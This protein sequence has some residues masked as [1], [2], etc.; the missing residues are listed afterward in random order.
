[1]TG[2]TDGIGKEIAA[3]LATAG[4]RVLIVGRDPEKGR[5]AEGPAV[6]FLRADL[7][8]GREADRLASDVADRVPALSF[9]VHSAGIVRGRRH[10]SGEGIESNFAV[11]Y[12]SRFV[13]STRLQPL[14]D[15]AAEVEGAPSR[16]LIVSGA[17]RNGVVEFDDVNLSK[18]FSTIRAVRQFVE[19]NDLLASELAER[20]SQRH[21]PIDVMCLKLGVVRTNIRRE[22]PGWMTVVVRLL[23]DPLLGLDPR[24]VGLAAIRLLLRTGDHG[25]DGVFYQFIRRMKPIAVPQSVRDPER[26]RRLWEL[27]ERLTAEAM[28]QRGHGACANSR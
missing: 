25:G 19:A 3:G 23:L 16:M 8:L 24:E 4:C 9:L 10:V 20:Q 27:S 28:R 18:H 6:E 5:R 26:R 17:A 1:V 14:L 15:R 2:G 7:S 22:F 11:N 21:T 12:L 13:L